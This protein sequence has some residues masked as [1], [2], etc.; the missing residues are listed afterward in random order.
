[1]F[2]HATRERHG[3]RFQGFGQRATVCY[4]NEPP[5]SCRAGC[6]RNALEAH[7]LTKADG[8][9]G[10]NHRANYTPDFEARWYGS[11]VSS[12]QANRSDGFEG[13][14]ASSKLQRVVSTNTLDGVLITDIEMA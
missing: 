13:D 7:V 6:S 3:I 2:W 5:Y 14:R 10:H 8:S 9:V 12:I 11:G 4:L 1:M